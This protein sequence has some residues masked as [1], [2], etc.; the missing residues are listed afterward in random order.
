MYLH[1]ITNVGPSEANVFEV[2]WIIVF[3]FGK[4]FHLSGGFAPDQTPSRFSCGPRTGSVGLCRD[5]QIL[6]GGVADQWWSP[7][8]TQG[9]ETL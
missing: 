6:G 4:L 1:Y 5:L 3:R 2:S 8:W 9:K 7:P